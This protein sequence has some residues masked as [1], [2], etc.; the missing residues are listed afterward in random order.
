MQSEV[1][2]TIQNFDTRGRLTTSFVLKATNYIDK[3]N[4]FQYKLTLIKHAYHF[5]SKVFAFYSSFFA[6]WIRPSGLFRLRI[7]FWNCESF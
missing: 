7:N 1:P 5:Q 4:I 6:S 3:G 2:A